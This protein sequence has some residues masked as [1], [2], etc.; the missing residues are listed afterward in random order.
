MK[1]EEL[2]RLMMG[3]KGLQEWEATKQILTREVELRRIRLSSYSTADM[4]SFTRAQGEINGILS[5]IS[6]IEDTKKVVD[7]F[8]KDA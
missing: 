8:V 4:L 6:L 5:V 2:V 1:N 3:L 7:K